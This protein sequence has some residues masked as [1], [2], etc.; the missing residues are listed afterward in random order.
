MPGSDRL[1]AEFF[2]PGVPVT[3]GSAKAF[4]I[5]GKDGSRPRAILTH[6]K[7]AELN[8]WRQRIG[9]AGFQA[10]VRKA[11]PQEPV[12]LEATFVLPRPASVSEKKRPLPIA[13]PD[14]DKLLRALKDGLTGINYDDDAQ[15]CEVIAKK[16]YGTETGVSVRLL[17]LSP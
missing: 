15:V 10:I 2:V 8:N 5:P 14:L 11:R 6:D 3:Q 16:R 1:L 9:L 7:R 13:K 4:V 17:S 12:C